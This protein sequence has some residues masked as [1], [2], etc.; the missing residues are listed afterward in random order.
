MAMMD[1]ALQN[2][3]FTEKQNWKTE[4][5]FHNHDEEQLS[6]SDAFW[7]VDQAKTTV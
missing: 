1:T 6:N 5:Q 4:R 2:K 7:N 3:S